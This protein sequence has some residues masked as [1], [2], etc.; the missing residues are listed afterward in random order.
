MPRASGHADDRQ[1]DARHNDAAVA[2]TRPVSPALSPTTLADTNASRPVSSM[3][4]TRSTSPGGSGVA[5]A[6]AGA[7]A[8]TRPASPVRPPAPAA[9]IDS[10]QPVSLMQEGGTSINCADVA[11]SLSLQPLTVQTHP[12]RQNQLEPLT[13]ELRQLLERARLTQHSCGLQSLGAAIV[14]DLGDI[15]TDQLRELGFRELEITRL[16]KEMYASR[17]EQYQ[18]RGSMLV[19]AEAEVPPTTPTTTGSDRSTEVDGMEV[20]LLS[21]EEPAK[22]KSQCT[23]NLDKKCCCCTRKQLL[24]AVGTVLTSVIAGVASIFAKTFVEPECVS[25]IVRCAQAECDSGVAVCTACEHGFYRFRH[26]DAAEHCIPD[27]TSMH[28]AMHAGPESKSPTEQGIFSFNFQGVLPTDLH[29]GSTLHVP[30]TWSVS[31]SGSG[32]EQIGADITVEGGGLTLTDVKLHSGSKVSVSSH[33]IL[34]M[35]NVDLYVSGF[36]VYNDGEL[37]IAGCTGTIPNVSIADS[38]FTVDPKTTAHFSGSIAFSNAAPV[39]LGQKTFDDGAQLSIDGTAASIGGSLLR[40]TDITVKSGSHLHITKCSGQIGDLLVDSAACTIDPASNL[41]LTRNVRFDNADAISLSHKT[42]TAGAQLAIGSNTVCSI[43]AS[44][45]SR[46]ALL[47]V[48]SGGELNMQSVALCGADAVSG[49]HLT[50]LQVAC[51]VNVTTSSMIALSNGELTMSGGHLAVLSLQCTGSATCGMTSL[52]ILPGAVVRLTGKKFNLREVLMS[53]AYVSGTGSD[54]QT[55]ATSF[56]VY[57]GQLTL[58]GGEL[59][60]GVVAVDGEGTSVALVNVN[61][62]AT[63]SAHTNGRLSLEKCSGTV[64]DI[65]VADSSFAADVVTTVSFEGKIHLAN[66]SEVRLDSLTFSDAQLIVEESTRLKMNQCHGTLQTLSIQESV[67]TLTDFSIAGFVQISHA[68]VTFNNIALEGAV[69][70]DHATVAM[71]GVTLAKAELVAY[72]STN[73]SMTGCHANTRTFNVSGLAHVDMVKC[74]GELSGMTV[75]GRHDIGP[76][77]SCDGS[78][79]TYCSWFTRDY[80]CHQTMPAFPHGCER[81]SSTCNGSPGSCCADSGTFL[82]CIGANC[83]NAVLGATVTGDDFTVAATKRSCSQRYRG[84]YCDIAPKQCRSQI[85]MDVHDGI[86]TGHGMF[87]C[88]CVESSGFGTDCTTRRLGLINDAR[89]L[90]ADVSC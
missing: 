15:T 69:N 1:E 80:N 81:N 21:S 77:G 27:T 59:S 88:D 16:R 68:T 70:M 33:G 56:L 75:D 4:N 24:V 78:V 13:D 30:L 25:A 79:R 43:E 87:G 48:E 46:G 14:A 35:I 26:D 74:D 45:I 6:N 62:N 57:G 86:C 83:Q 7:A 50:D 9:Q 47:Q 51:A 65:D 73:L 38:K 63:L 18:P 85:K 10:L 60:T 44:A 67:A 23:K 82:R 58:A 32:T 40:N 39:S 22:A 28:A 52:S 11:E 5:R 54:L 8:V 90:D 12:K 53:G 41:R 76:M 37:D 17:G 34:K 19:Q 55:D 71:N 36:D 89:C 29:R 84:P 2:V 3:H 61:L 64:T 49:A 31:I 42:F 72:G 20:P 66:A